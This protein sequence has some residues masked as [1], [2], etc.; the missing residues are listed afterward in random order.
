MVREEVQA[1]RVGGQPALST[2]ARVDYLL[3]DMV[4]LDRSAVPVAILK[5]KSDDHTP[6]HGLEPAKLQAECERLNVISSN[7]HQWG[8]FHRTPCH[9]SQ[10]K[11]SSGQMRILIVEDDDKIA[12][13]VRSGL[14]QAGHVPSTGSPTPRR[15]LR[16]AGIGG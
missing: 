12:S 2:L 1:N 15:R 11:A 6:D 4:N 3:Q 14:A 7:G 9:A 16:A 13:F 10:R 8:A 5:S